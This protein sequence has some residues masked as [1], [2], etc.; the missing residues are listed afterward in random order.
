MRY[1][2]LNPFQFTGIEID[3]QLSN[4]TNKRS[5]FAGGFAQCKYAICRCWVFPRKIKTFSTIRQNDK[6]P[7]LLSLISR[8]KTTDKKNCHLSVPKEIIKNMV[9]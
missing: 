1:G 6:P 9:I 3:K 2:K 5:F 4:A 7:S 8:E